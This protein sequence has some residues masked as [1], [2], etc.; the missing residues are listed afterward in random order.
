[1]KATLPHSEHESYLRH[2]KQLTRQIILPMVLASLLMVALSVLIGF[3]TFRD[4]GDV[5]RWAAVST[6]WIVIPILLAGLIFLVILLGLVY[7]MA[8]LL[9]VLPTYTGL[10]Q[11]YVHLGAAYV[12]RFTEA[13]VKPVF[14]VDGLAA[15]FKAIFG[16][17]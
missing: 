13:A 3:A 4:N 14:A 10:A 11:D 7:L 17:K 2:R 5:G 1:M 16:R 15:Y 9:G 6:I 12:Q 8:R